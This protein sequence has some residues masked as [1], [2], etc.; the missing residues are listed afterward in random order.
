MGQLHQPQLSD[1]ADEHFDNIDG[2]CDGPVFPDG[3][4]PHLQ[5]YRNLATARVYV[6]A[7]EG[8]VQQAEFVELQLQ[9]V[10]IIDGDGSHWVLVA[11][12]EF[13][14]GEQDLPL[15]TDDNVLKQGVGAGAVVDQQIEFIG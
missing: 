10:E 15:V 1:H 3:Q 6:D 7:V 14:L 5:V 4:N 9:T 13:N 11:S 2:V 8:V 12:Q